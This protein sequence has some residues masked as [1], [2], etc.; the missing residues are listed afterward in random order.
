MRVNLDWLGDWTDVSVGPEAVASALTAAGLEVDEVTAVAA[1]LDGIVV[2]AVRKVERH[3]NADRLSV[4]EVDDGSAVHRVVCGAPN[5]RADIKAPFARIGSR[6]PDG[7]EIEAAE[8]RGVSS[9]GMLCSAKELELSDDAAGL[10]LLDADAPVGAPLRDYL[11]LDDTA[12]EV[13]VTPNRGDCFSVVGLAREI[14]ASLGNA[15]RKPPAS[16]VAPAHGETFPVTLTAAAQCP[17]FAGRVVTGLATDRKSP[18][19]LRERLR[20]AGLRAIHPVVDVTNYVMLELGQPLH[21]YDLGKLAAG[22]DVRLAKSGEPLVLLDGKALEL[23]DDVLVIAD[24]NGAIGLAG[25]MG[26]QSTAVSAASDTVFLESAYFTPRAITGRARRFGLH[27]DA[28]LRF[29]RGVDPTGQA[30]AIERATELLLG[31]CG[32]RAGPVVVTEDRK[33][34]PARGAIVLRRERLEALLGMALTD[35]QIESSL[36]RLEM[37]VERGPG[38]WRITPPAFRFDLAIEEDLIEEVG[39]MIGYD[40]VPITPAAATEQLGAATEKSVAADRALD[41]LVARGYTEVIT[42]S[43]IDPELE[44][45]I[46]P[47]ATQV[48]LANPIASDL[49]VLRRSLWPGLI[50]AARRNVAHQRA[51]LKLVEVGPQ[52]TADDGR[53]AETAV[54]AGIVLGERLPEHWDGAAPPLDFFDV[55]GDIESLLDMTGM[56]TEFRFE[57]ATHPALSPGRTARIIRANETVGWLGVLHPNVQ[58]LIDRKRSAVVFA[59]QL[60]RAFV[61]SVPQFEHYSKFPSIR[62]DLAIVVDEQT[63]V[64]TITATVRAA[65]GTLLQELVIFDVYRGPGVDSRRKSVGLGLILQDTYRTLTDADADKTMQSVTLRL[66]R[67]LGATIRT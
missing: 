20:R 58:E 44:E 64:E 16:A 12:L 40:E 60:E 67:E 46:N 33:R 54:L 22:I 36:E 5:V 30:R 55:K 53:V 63:P 38:H 51:R 10:L 14:A 26:G 27:T 1:P 65:A 61:A 48:P 9:Q 3:P 18:L 66:E 35:E 11:R 32:G 6:L 28:S 52:F 50:V 39:R 62:R 21:A 49:A 37:Q 57:A 2:G 24:G 47:G 17:R 42:Y 45:A 59:L 25:I 34:A 15:F 8:L 29:E 19:W 13:N 31:I 43:F 23:Q 41:V 56:G 4:C 7:R